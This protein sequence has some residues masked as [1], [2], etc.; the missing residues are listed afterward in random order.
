MELSSASN[1]LAIRG[2]IKT[3]QDFQDIKFKLEMMKIEFLDI[4]IKIE[5]S[6]SITSSVI[7]YLN[8]LV[9]KDG[10]KLTMQVANKQLLE[11]FRDLNLTQTFNVKEV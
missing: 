9:L 1:T 5:D 7:G 3:I 10:I 8:K 6:I 4:T 2:N 11:L